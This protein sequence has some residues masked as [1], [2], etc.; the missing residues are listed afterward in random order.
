MVDL[1]QLKTR[2]KEVSELE[3]PVVGKLS[4]ISPKPVSRGQLALKWGRGNTGYGL[5]TLGYIFISFQTDGLTHNRSQSIYLTAFIFFN[6]KGVCL[7]VLFTWL[8]LFIGRPWHFLSQQVP[9]PPCFGIYH[10]SPH[11]LMPRAC[12]HRILL[13]AFYLAA[14]NSEEVLAHS[15]EAEKFPPCKGRVLLV[16]S[17]DCSL[18]LFSSRLVV[19]F[20]RVPTECYRQCQVQTCIIISMANGSSMFTATNS[21]HRLLELLKHS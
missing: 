16:S 21:Q 14:E 17:P 18:T 10:T 5:G 11:P 15:W 9:D 4:L 1:L 8:I 13:S 6:L 7:F 3:G 12:N 19:S 20:F 2:S